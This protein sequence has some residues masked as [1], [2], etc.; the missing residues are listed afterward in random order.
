MRSKAF[1]DWLLRHRALVLVTIL[2]LAGVVGYG[3]RRVRVDYGVEQFFLERGPERELYDEYKRL[4][5]GEDT[6][7]SLFW[8]DSRPAGA[9][10]YRDMERVAGWFE[11]VGLEDVRW[12]GNIVV[13]E[14]LSGDGKPGVR[15]GPLVPR[16]S[17]TDAVV[18]R[19]LR[20]HRDD[21]LLQGFL[22]DSTQTVLLIHGYL[23]PGANVDT[24]RRRIDAALTERLETLRGDDGPKLVLTGLP[25]ARARAPVLLESDQR[26]L[27][28]AAF[29]VF[30]AILYWFFRHPAHV[31]LSLVS[32]APA[33]L[34]VLGA[35]GYAG[36][37]ISILTSFIPI[38]VLVVGMSDAVHIL[39]HFR[40]RRAQGG[41][42]NAAIAD[43]FAA[44]A[45]PCWY[46]SVTTAVGFAALAGTR[47]G[48]V[49]DF[50]LLTAI[51]ILLAF[52]FSMT[53]FPVLL[54]LAPLGAAAPKQPYGRRWLDAVVAAAARRARR[55]APGIVVATVIVALLA[56]GLALRLRTD[57]YL[58]DD[59][60]ESAPFMQD[61]AWIDQRGFGFFQVNVL[62][63]Q[64]GPRPLYAPESLEWMAQLR[65]RFES[66]PLVT[67]IVA[68]PDF[69]GQLRRAALGPEADPI[70]ET[71]GAANQLLA[72][73]RETDPGF[74]HEIY[75]EP[76]GVAQ[77][78]ITVRDEGSRVTQPLLDRLHTYL[79]HHPF[80]NGTARVTGTVTM[81]HSF[82]QRLLQSFGPSIVIAIVV[83]T[84]IMMWLLKSVRLGLI[85]L[86]PNVIP[87]VVVLGAMSAL[88]Y[89]LKPSTILVLSIAF[90]IAVDNTIH[91]LT[92]VTRHAGRHA[93]VSSGLSRGL[94]E[95]GAVMIVTSAIVTAGFALLLASHFTVLV[96]I[97]LMT[98]LT[99]VT[100]LVA[101]LFVLPAAV[102]MAETHS[103]AVAVPAEARVRSD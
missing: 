48:I 65:A 92:R 76:A 60:K 38:V 57:T 33:Y 19:A 72:L 23:A 29:V 86:L 101:D 28:G 81:I 94:T 84:A 88:G 55:P 51:G 4:F 97:G 2:I 47:I 15:V 18:A 74:A 25:I 52:G 70:P 66:E 11:D 17:V 43:T 10:L 16:D 26:L 61:I 69:L 13:A 63:K 80:P 39:A 90:G 37:P 45:V 31:A 103:A 44:M 27:L 95:A 67:Q 73:A 3:A 12:F 22:W 20:R 56:F 5:P 36:K 41:T 68:L 64:V 8:S 93:P 21:P 79:E 98:A 42:R 87:L 96:L 35:V 83:I 54:S 24:T 71:A 50:G 9:A 59:T 62:L 102:R 7:V 53:L 46:T 32:V 85:A 91:L 34:C 1:F 100:A 49:V 75:R 77:V 40:D 6:R 89:A 58:I 78:I 14:H 30:F 82:T 99:A